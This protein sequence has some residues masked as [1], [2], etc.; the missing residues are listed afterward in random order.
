MSVRVPSGVPQP[1]G[2]GEDPLTQFAR[3]FTKF[4]QVVF[5][6]FEK[7]AYRWNADER[8]SDITISDQN[9]IDKEVVE[10]RP[11]I[12]IS[13]GPAAFANI[14]LDQFAG[15][16]LTWPNGSA[17]PPNFTPNDDPVTGAMRHTDLMSASMTYNCLSREG[18]EAQRIAW[19]AMYATRVLKRFL[20]NAGLHRV[21]EELQVGSESPPG[22]IVT[23]DPNEII[24][25]AV[26][27]PFY[28]Q[29]TWTTSPLNKSL[30]TKVAIALSSEIE[31]PAPGA[32]AIREPGINGRLIGYDKLLTLEQKIAQGL[33]KTPKPRT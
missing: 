8:N 5:A 18:I 15:P 19:I 4:L 30:L 33:I 27:V 31:W 21:G 25:V 9:P 14:S 20:L 16:L 10:K 28:F 26:Q 17:Q 2:F 7:G 22:S 13:R 6:T 1:Q 3:L 24:L 23:G 11:A 32:T 29:D 12:I